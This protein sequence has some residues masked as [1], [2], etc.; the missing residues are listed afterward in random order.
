MERTSRGFG[1]IGCVTDS[2]GLVI[3]AIE[4]DRKAV[5]LAVLDYMKREVVQN[6]TW[7]M[8]QLI[9]ATRYEVEKG[10]LP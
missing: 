4:A 3:D 7:S 6:E 2:R 10:E 8:L 5:A 1:I 9:S